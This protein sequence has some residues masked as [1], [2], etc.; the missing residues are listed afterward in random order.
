MKIYD[1]MWS[2]RLVK[3]TIDYIQNL[4][5]C[6]YSIFQFK[7][8][9][10]SIFICSNIIVELTNMKHIYIYISNQTYRILC[11]YIHIYVFMYKSKI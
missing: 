6:K 3:V 8:D 5:I 1:Q 9:V 7:Q 11:I 4:S 2:S 10:T